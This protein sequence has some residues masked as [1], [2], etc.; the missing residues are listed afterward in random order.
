MKRLFEIQ[1]N[2]SGI[3]YDKNYGS[4]KK[5]GWSIYIDGHFIVFFEKY[6]IIALF[7]AIQWEINQCIG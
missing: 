2:G 4:L 5:S 7:K 3:Q 1:F 6:L